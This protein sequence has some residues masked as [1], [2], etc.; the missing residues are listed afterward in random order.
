MSDM[1]IYRPSLLAADVLVPGLV[2]LCLAVAVL[3]QAADALGQAAVV[4]GLAAVVFGQAA[5]VFSPAAES[6][7]FYIRLLM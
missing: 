7:M 5:D 6:L 1:N 3:G 2:A 4:S